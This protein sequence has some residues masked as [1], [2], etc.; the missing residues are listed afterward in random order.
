MSAVFFEIKGT[1][2]NLSTISYLQKEDVYG[3]HTIVMFWPGVSDLNQPR[4]EFVFNN[5]IERDRIYMALVNK[6]Q[7]E[8]VFEHDYA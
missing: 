8:S 4:R 3:S 5:K 1:L 2:V 7:A 6:I